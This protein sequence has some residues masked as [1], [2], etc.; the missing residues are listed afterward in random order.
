MARKITVSFDSVPEVDGYNIRRSES[1]G[2]GE[3]APLN[4]ELLKSTVYVDDTALPGV[5]YFYKVTSV[6]GSLE[7]D[8]SLEARSPA[9]PSAPKNVKAL[10][11][12]DVDP[13]MSEAVRARALANLAEA[14]AIN[15]RAMADE[16]EARA[17]KANEKAIEADALADKAEAAEADVLPPVESKSKSK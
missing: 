14:E 3:T 4:A 6:R 15:A 12:G 16:A 1:H 2:F 9:L 11:E 10:E 8:L 17:E 13:S 7:S 5:V